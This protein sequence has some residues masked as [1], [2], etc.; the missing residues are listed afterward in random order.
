MKP[1]SVIVCNGYKDPAFIQNALIGTK[2][3]KRVILVVEKLEELQQIRNKLWKAKISGNIFNE[4]L[5]RQEEIE[6][7]KL[8]EPGHMFFQRSLEKIFGLLRASTMGF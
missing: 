7:R 3:G 2:L 5:Y 6:F 8:A 4:L 1:G